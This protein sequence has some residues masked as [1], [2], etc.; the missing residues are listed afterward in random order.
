MEDF[1]QEKTFRCLIQTLEDKPDNEMIYDSMWMLSNIFSLSLK[2]S[3]IEMIQRLKVVDAVAPFLNLDNYP[4]DQFPFDP[5]SYSSKILS[6]TLWALNNL[7]Q[8]KNSHIC[9]QVI[10]ETEVLYTITEIIQK[11]KLTEETETLIS[12]ATWILS[13]IFKEIRSDHPQVSNLVEVIIEF[14]DEVKPGEFFKIDT[15]ILWILN[16]VSDLSELLMQKMIQKRVFF[17]F[18]NHYID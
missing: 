16:Y 15:D 9:L 11:T 7:L 1:L 4:E 5:K 13:T 12:C 2:A 18:I 14:F 3:H 6:Q 8:E 17:K 10:N